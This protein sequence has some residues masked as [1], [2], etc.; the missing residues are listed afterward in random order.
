MNHDFGT[1]QK[2]MSAHR[3]ESHF[4][5]EDKSYYPRTNTCYYFPEIESSEPGKKIP[6]NRR[7]RDLRLKGIAE[8]RIAEA[9]R[10][11]V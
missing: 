3:E 7:A 4:N 1:K 5:E 10:L 9:I 6:L 11:S 2:N 8:A